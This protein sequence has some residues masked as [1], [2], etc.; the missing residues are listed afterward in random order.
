MGEMGKKTD[1]KAKS[2]KKSFQHASRTYL[3]W[4][5]D[6]SNPQD[7]QW[8]IDRLEL[9]GDW[10]RNPKNDRKPWGEKKTR[11][12]KSNAWNVTITVLFKPGEMCPLCP[13]L[14][15][16]KHKGQVQSGWCWN[17]WS[18]NHKASKGVFGRLN[19]SNHLADGHKEL[20]HSTDSPTKSS[21]L[22]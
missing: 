20:G 8:P 10:F 15:Y 11:C 16:G 13:V 21:R 12:T 17:S 3:K 7:L 22:D 9:L 5:Q 18:I 19:S 1:E 14:V 4:L 2:N 6:C